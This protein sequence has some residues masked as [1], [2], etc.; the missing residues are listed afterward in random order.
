MDNLTKKEMQEQYKEREIIGGVYAIRNTQNNKL[1]VD[2]ATDIQ[3]SRNRFEFAVKTGSCIH[4]KLQS[5][6]TEQNGKYF[7]FE[8]LDELRKGDTQSQ[9]EFKADVEL[10][11]ELRLEKLSGENLY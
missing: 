5:D 8:I 10:M 4:P 7:S 1:L 9:K 11:K 3:G 2:A 6:W